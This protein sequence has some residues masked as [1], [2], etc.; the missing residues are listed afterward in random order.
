MLVHGVGASR[1]LI[2]GGLG[3]RFDLGGHGFE[4]RALLALSGCPLKFLLLA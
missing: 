2:H 3:F 4:R 1:H